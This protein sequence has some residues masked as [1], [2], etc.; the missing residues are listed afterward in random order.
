MPRIHVPMNR[1]RATPRMTP[2][3]QGCP[4]SHPHLEFRCPSSNPLPLETSHSWGYRPW[5]QYPVYV[6]SPTRK[7][8]IPAF[9]QSPGG[10]P[11]PVSKRIS[12]SPKSYR[13]GWTWRGSDFNGD[14][15]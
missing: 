8:T 4:D 3:L 7:T 15:Y 12:R 10:D 9:S 13:T 11:P 5:P 14:E 6:H 2:T 1:V